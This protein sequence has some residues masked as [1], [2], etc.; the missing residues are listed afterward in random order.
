MIDRNDSLKRVAA[1]SVKIKFKCSTTTGPMFYRIRTKF[2]IEYQEQC[3]IISKKIVEEN[4]QPHLMK[5]ESDIDK[6]QQPSF[7][8]PEFLLNNGSDKIKIIEN[9]VWKTEMKY[10]GNLTT[11]SDIN[12]QV[13]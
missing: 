9:R 6:N 8:K 13:W 7:I 3:L 12:Q 5:S 1:K 4:Q 10:W 11:A 2:R